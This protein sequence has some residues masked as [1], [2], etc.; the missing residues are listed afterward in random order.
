ML[1]ILTILND[2]SKLN[3]HRIP[4]NKEMNIKKIKAMK[5]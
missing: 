2:V 5:N 4:Q 3:N 1:V